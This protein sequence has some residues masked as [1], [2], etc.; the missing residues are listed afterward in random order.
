MIDCPI[1]VAAGLMT[2]VWAEGEHLRQAAITGLRR[3]GL[4]AVYRQEVMRSDALSYGYECELKGV[5]ARQNRP[6]H[7]LLGFDLFRTGAVEGWPAGNAALLLVGYG[8][9]ASDPWDMDD[10]V[11]GSD[12]RLTDPDYRASLTPMAAFG[13]RLLAFES[14]ASLPMARRSWLYAVPL[15]RISGPVEVDRNIVEPLMGLLARDG[16][17]PGPLLASSA[18]EWPAWSAAAA[19]SPCY[20][21]HAS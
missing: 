18:I 21:A 12:G 16:V 2:K 15:G 11:F 17:R 14:E 9:K 19:V 7:L 1:F 13:T 5:Y 10:L 20:P 4:E 8:P 3:A 6:A